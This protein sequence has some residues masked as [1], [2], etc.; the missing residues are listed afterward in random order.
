MGLSL[1]ACAIS[2]SEGTG[3]RSLSLVGTNG[4]TAFLP[5][6]D[7]EAPTFLTTGF[8]AITFLG[9]AFLIFDFPIGDFVVAI[10]APSVENTTYI[11]RSFQTFD[12]CLLSLIFV[13]CVTRLAGEL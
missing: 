2:I 11:I 7:K 9:E 8:F 10:F 1:P 6:E 13:H 4:T 3:R 12:N 5:L